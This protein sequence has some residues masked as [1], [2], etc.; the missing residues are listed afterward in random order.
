MWNEEEYACK[1]HEDFERSSYM[2]SLYRKRIE[3]PDGT[4]CT[5]APPG[6]WSFWMAS[7]VTEMV[8]KA[9]VWVD[10]KGKPVIEIEMKT[11]QWFLIASAVTAAVL[12]YILYKSFYDPESSWYTWRKDQAVKWG[13]ASAPPPVEDAGDSADASGPQPGINISIA[14]S[15]GSQPTPEAQPR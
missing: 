2:D 8:C 11:A 7:E 13:F 10:G 9:G 14:N 1:E 12:V 4:K 6:K 3:M 15:S 5:V